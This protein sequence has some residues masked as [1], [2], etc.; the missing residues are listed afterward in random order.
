MNGT[1]ESIVKETK[2]KQYGRIAD[3]RG[4]LNVSISYSMEMNAICDA[5][6]FNYNRANVENRN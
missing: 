2:G 3:T 1:R 6:L 5:K 4:T